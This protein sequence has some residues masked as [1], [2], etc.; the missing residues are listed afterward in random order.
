[1]CLH[2]R[3]IPGGF[4]SV[5]K[6]S[7]KFVRIL[8]FVHMSRALFLT[9]NLTL[10]WVH[11]NSFSACCVCQRLIKI[12]GIAV[13]PSFGDAMKPAPAV[14]VPCNSSRHTIAVVCVISQVI[15]DQLLKGARN[16]ACSRFTQLLDV[17]HF[18]LVQLS[19]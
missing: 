4:A 15:A 17:D 3:G 10:G 18:G 16:A 9:D 5:E 14:I 1:V 2:L 6:K 7:Q 8:L 11:T 19:S 13:E 12:I